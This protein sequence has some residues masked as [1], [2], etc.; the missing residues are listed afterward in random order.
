MRVR[1]PLLL[2]LL[3]AVI[4]AAP[5]GAALPDPV[6]CRAGPCFT[7]APGT[8]WQWQISGDRVRTVPGVELYDF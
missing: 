3:L 6:P 2:G 4:C 5:A 8:V 7:P 1:R